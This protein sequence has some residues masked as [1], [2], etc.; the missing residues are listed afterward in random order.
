MLGVLTDNHDN[1]LSLDDLALFAHFLDG[2]SY[3]HV[4]TSIF[5][6]R[7]QTP[8]DS[9]FGRIV[10]GHFNKY[11]VAG[12]DLNVSLSDLARNMGDDNH[13]IG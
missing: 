2:R 7:L 3:L 9:A 4:T 6:R 11:P 13:I 1:A 8:G 10:H 12:Y 5:R